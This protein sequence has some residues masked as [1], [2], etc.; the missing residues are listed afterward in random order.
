MLPR[1]TAALAGPPR[2]AEPIPAGTEGSARC[3]WYR[4]RWALRDLYEPGALR[5]N[6]LF[7]AACRAR[8]L[9]DAGSLDQAR[10]EAL[11]LDAATQV[12]LVR[13]DSE[14]RWPRRLCDGRSH[15]DQRI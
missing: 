6:A 9:I 3:A 11:L 10:A 7:R 1:W 13:D 14:A 4:L 5:N 15:A 2:R 8:E 12:G